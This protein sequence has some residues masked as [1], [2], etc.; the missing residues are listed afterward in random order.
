[1]QFRSAVRIVPAALASVAI[2]CGQAAAQTPPSLGDLAKKEQER[3]KQTPS[4]TKVLTNKDLPK[5]AP[6]PAPPP[7]S[8]A[9]AAPAAEE[10]KPEG[11]VKDEAYWRERMTNLRDEI[12]KNELFLESLQSRINA[13]ATDFAMRD[14]PY[15]RIKVGEE[16][17]KSLAMMDRV[18]GDI[19]KLKKA[20]ADL[21]EEARKEGVPPGWLR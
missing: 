13:L 20:I 18:R 7:A 17:Q 5:A 2:L 6:Q 10:K 12:T 14:D 15:Q 16:R 3:R 9:A 21:E 19:E 1:M 11:E 4:A 8:A